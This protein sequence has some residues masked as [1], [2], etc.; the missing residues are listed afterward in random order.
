MPGE[1]EDN[2]SP[3]RFKGAAVKGKT[4][5][6]WGESSLQ[7]I[8]KQKDCSNIDREEENGWP[9]RITWKS[10]RHPIGHNLNVSWAAVVCPMLGYKRY[11]VAYTIFNL[12]GKWAVISP[13][14]LACLSYILPTEKQNYLKKEYTINFE[15]K[16]EHCNIHSVQIRWQELHYSNKVFKSRLALCLLLRQSL[17]LS[18]QERQGRSGYTGQQVITERGWTVF[19]SF[20][21]L[22][23]KNNFFGK[24]SPAQCAAIVD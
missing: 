11:K 23:W 2:C 14:L 17:E 22:Y 16:I 21:Y 13:M 18:G 12:H 10:H 19:S 7:T 20:P 15:Y 6:G 24:L 1:T 8:P 9:L 5:V 3:E 4:V